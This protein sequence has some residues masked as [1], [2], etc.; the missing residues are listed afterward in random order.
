LITI[1]DEFCLVKLAD[2]RQWIKV[3]MSRK[4]HRY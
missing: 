3:I 2:K 4:H 1:F